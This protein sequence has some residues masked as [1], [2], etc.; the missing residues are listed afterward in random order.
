MKINVSCFLI[1]FIL[2]SANLMAQ[3]SIKGIV[4]DMNTGNPLAGA[5]IIIQNAGRSAVSDKNG[6]FFIQDIEAGN[7]ILNVQYVGYESVSREVQTGKNHEK[8]VSIYLSSRAIDIPAVIITASRTEDNRKYIPASMDAIEQSQIQ[9]MPVLSP[10]DLL[11][12]VTGVN[13][14][15][16]YG[17]F[18]KTGNV[19]MRGLNRNIH[20]LVLLDN[21]PFSLSD[22]SSNV[23]NKLSTDNIDNIQIVK[24]PNSSLYGSNAMSGVINILSVKPDRKFQGRAKAF[25]GS[26]NTFGGMFNMMGTLARPKGFYWK[27]NAFL[28]KSDGYIMVPDSVRQESDVKT[29]LL[30][31]HLGATVGYQFADKNYIEAE[32]DYSYDHRDAGSKFFEDDGSYNQY[33][34]H[35]A[36]ISYNKTKNNY[37]IHANGFFKRE[38]Y[39][40][41]NE[42]VKKNSGN[43]TFYNTE[44]I[45]QDM[46]LWLSYTRKILGAHYLT[47]GCDYKNGSSDSD[48]IYRTS[49]DTIINIGKMRYFGGFIQDVST[50]FNGKLSIMAAL[51]FDAVFFH[52]GVF[53]IHSPSLITEFLLPYEEDFPD[54]NWNTFSPKAGI[55]YNFNKKYNVYTSYAYGF[56]PPT[57]SDMTRTG[58]VSK[59]FKLANPDLKPEHIHSIELG[60]ELMPLQ[61]LFINPVIFFS[62]GNDF[63]YFVSTGDSVITSGSNPKPVIKRE[64]IGNVHIAGAE[65]KVKYNIYRGM[66]LTACYTFNHSQIAEYNASAEDN[67]DLKGKFLIDVPKNLVSLIWQWNNKIVNTCIT[68]KYNGAEWADDEN[69]FKMAPYFLLDMKISK[70]FRNTVGLSLSI[71]NI[72]DKRIPDSKGYVSPGRFIL[73][74]IFYNW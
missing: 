20:N 2:L 6:S 51:R 22:G 74:E 55:K 57:V 4:L 25:Y 50:L 32:Y 3:Y 68:A 39:L 59:G 61:S 28:R 1:F 11:I 7:Y 43:Y 66:S 54:K 19:I 42:G 45:T 13:A 35:F 67:K 63:Q 41:Q 31:Y 12:L 70:T 17:I 23:W 72:L 46:G 24:G 56:R 33:R 60:S 48:D 58:D 37:E 44:A 30:E 69:T 14:A 71:Q 15:R 26:F 64:N 10:D 62:V 34:T 27:T 18:N 8:F 49:T 53:Q 21:V 36:R 40:R 29:A 52:K 47:V 5:P 16:N 9:Q 65:I 73:A 38:N